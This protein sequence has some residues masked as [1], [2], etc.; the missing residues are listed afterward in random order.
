MKYQGLIGLIFLCELSAVFAEESTT[1][2][3][4]SSDSK[5]NV[6][7]LFITFRESLEGCVIISLLLNMLDKTGLH[8]LK[9]W[10]WFGACSGI[11]GFIVVGAILISVF[12]A[13]KSSVPEHFMYVFEGIL[14][15]FASFILAA[16]GLGFLRLKDLEKKWENKLFNRENVKAPDAQTSWVKQ[17]IAQFKDM[18]SIRHQAIDEDV[19]SRGVT[20]WMIFF[21][22]FSSL[23]REGVETVFML[24]FVNADPGGLALGGAVGSVCGIVFGYLVMVIGKYFL[25]DVSMFFNLTTVFILFIAAG[26]SRYGSHE[27]EELAAEWAADRNDPVIMRSLYDL[28]ESWGPGWTHTTGW[29][30]VARVLLGY[31]DNPTLIEALAYLCFWLLVVTII[32]KRYKRG[33][34]FTR[35]APGSR[36]SSESD[37]EEKPQHFDAKMNVEQPVPSV[38][39]AFH[40][41][42]QGEILPV[43]TAMQHPV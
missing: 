36:A 32:L 19:R 17:K 26:L 12:Y 16:L 40:Q 6:P 39:I 30:A 31:S 7:A 25:V 42:L 9:R 4:S 27:F 35:F 33:T 24:L 41:P 3:S 8:E 5:F 13:I 18:L 2:S 20:P 28:T 43:W 14:A 38:A 11:A 1:T 22:A 34:L 10:V 21:I 37:I 15:L 29:G 23:F